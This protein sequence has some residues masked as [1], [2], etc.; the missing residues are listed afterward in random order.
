M[1]DYGE[2][3]ETAIREIDD[4]WQ[5]WMQKYNLPSYHPNEA[6]C[7]LIVEYLLQDEG[8]RNVLDN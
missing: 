7:D 6:G 5:N 8:I 3:N 1:L 4:I 2:K